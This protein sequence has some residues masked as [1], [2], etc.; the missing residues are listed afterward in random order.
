MSSN[1]KVLAAIESSFRL[2]PLDLGMTESQENR[3]QQRIY[4]S[5]IAVLEEES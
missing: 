2:W 1:A 5:V 3:F 4:E